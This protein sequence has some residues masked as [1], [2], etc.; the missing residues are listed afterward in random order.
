MELNYAHYNLIFKEPAI[1][2]RSTMLCKETF[3]LKYIPQGDDTGALVGEVPLFRGLSAEDD[4]GFEQRLKQF[5]AGDVATSLPVDSSV[6][7]AVESIR[8]QMERLRNPVTEQVRI[9]I[10]GLV[11]M[12]D[13]R[14]MFNR[15]RTKLDAGFRCVKLK[16]GG[17][18]FADELDLIKY[19]R[20][21]FSPSDLELRLDA[22]GAFNPD[23]ALERLK[24]LSDHHIHSIEQPIRQ[25]QWERM[26]ELTEKSPIPIALDEELIGPWCCRSDE[27]MAALLDAVA[28]HYIILKPSLCG[29]FDV[30]DRWIAA[31]TKRGIGWWATSALESNIGL[32][33]I[34]LWL[35]R[36]NP[37]I[38]QGLGTG[39][40]YTNN[41]ESALHMEADELVYD[42]W[43]NVSAPELEWK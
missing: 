16:I 32:T 24:W 37:V 40:L 43:E 7:F 31:A 23:S 18:D 8:H 1:T 15:I 28:P 33:A 11:W 19:I 38:P 2:S 13:K 10:N 42:P 3:F 25:G 12:G 27:A 30:A 9:P 20:G 26:R 36:H 29:G 14:T 6:A 35:S 39:S 22:N 4:A 5:C 34:T 21:Q 41:F 17:I